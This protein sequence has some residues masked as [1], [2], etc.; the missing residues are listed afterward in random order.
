MLV[1]L[2]ITYDNNNII[3][4]LYLQIDAIVIIVKYEKVQTDY[5]YIFDIL[6][7]QNC[8]FFYSSDYWWLLSS[9][10][11]VTNECQAGYTHNNINLGTS[12]SN[13]FKIIL[14]ILTIIYKLK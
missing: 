4:V 12:F 7:K 8:D 14:S 3:F 10:I 5:D 13:G 9:K 11:V 6:R 2:L 1:F